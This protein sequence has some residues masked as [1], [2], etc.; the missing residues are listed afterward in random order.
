MTLVSE[1][2]LWG[3]GAGALVKLVFMY[4]DFVAE[5][6][7]LGKMTRD[8]LEAVWVALEEMT[9]FRVLQGVLGRLVERVR[10]LFRGS[11]WR[12][13][14][15]VWLGSSTLSMG[16]VIFGVENESRLELILVAPLAVVM[17]LPVGMFG[18]FSAWITWFLIRA[19]GEASTWSQARR[20]LVFE[21]C[22]GVLTVFWTRLSLG[23]IGIVAC[24]ASAALSGGLCVVQLNM[25]G[26]LIPS[27]GATF[28]AATSAVPS[29]AYLSIL[30][31]AFAARACPRWLHRQV[32]NFVFALCSKDTPVFGALGN[33]SSAVFGV[34]A[35]VGNL[36]V[37]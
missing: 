13:L 4:L 12:A 20:H 33:F 5:V 8:R 14:A 34:A 23:A 18:V 15:A 17:L 10:R 37:G 6:D 36:V 28:V 16:A 29:L 32:T 1:A 3:T 30:S 35:A 27:M 22:L 7:G 21:V 26:S 31:L 11:R 19:A 24:H 9:A 25:D 2:L